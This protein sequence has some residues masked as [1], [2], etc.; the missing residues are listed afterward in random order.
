MTFEQVSEIRSRNF[1]N[2]NVTMPVHAASA[3]RRFLD[4]GYDAV[5]IEPQDFGR[6]QRTMTKSTPTSIRSALAKKIE[7]LALE[8]TL[9]TFHVKGHVY[10]VRV[11]S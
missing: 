8:T 4:S 7:E 1:N 11:D 9:S 5:E 2:G 10:L 3:I 6:T